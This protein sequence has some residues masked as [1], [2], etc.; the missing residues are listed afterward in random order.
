MGDIDKSLYSAVPVWVDEWNGMLFV[1]FSPDEPRPVA[2]HLRNADFSAFA[3]D[4][5]RVVQDRTYPVASNWKLA[6]ETFQ[7]CYHCPNLHPEFAT[8]VDPLKDL[9]AWDEAETE[10]DYVIF[11]RD[12]T[13]AII[14]QGTRTFSMTGDIECQKP[15][16]NGR[17]WRREIS[18]LSWFPQ[19]GMFVFPD[20]AVTYSWKPV[21]PTTCLFRS[22]WLV[23]KDAVEGKDY[24]L[25]KLIKF[26]DLLN[27]QDARACEVAQLG[28][29]SSGYRPGPYHP[30]FEGPV[31]GFNRIYLMQVA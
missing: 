15:L 20:H 24:E 12:M 11:T 30:V 3:L 5:T 16:G 8:L 4:Q 25:E 14:K 23:H 27:H 29:Q 18:A 26:G 17:D 28:V 2:D 9:E 1:N 19:F 13:S 31:R 10:D 21:S 6:A 22:T 7:E